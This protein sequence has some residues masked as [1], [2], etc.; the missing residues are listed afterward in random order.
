[1]VRWNEKMVMD[2]IPPIAYPIIL[3]GLSI[4][5]IYR[6]KINQV[7]ET[8]SLGS[9]YAGLSLLFAS[10]LMNLLQRHP[11]YHEWFLDSVYPVVTIG[12]L[13]LIV[14]GMIFLVAGLIIYFSYWRDSEIE[15]T[16]QLE[17]LKVLDNLQ[18]E[19]RYPYQMLE[20]LDRVLKSMLSGLEEEAGAIFLLNRSQ[21][22]FV[23]ATGFGLT[24]E[25]TALLEYYPYG[26]N[27]I[28]QAIEDESPMISADFRS[29]GG[30]AQLAASKFR[31]IL[32]VP[33]ISGKNKLGVL[34]IFS[35]EDRHYSREFIALVT[36]IAEWLSGKIEVN[37]LGRELRKSQQ[38]LESKS[39]R[40]SSFVKQVGGIIR[41][42]TEIPSL[43]VFAEKCLG[44]AGSDEVW[45]IGLVGGR[46]TFYGGTQPRAD[47]SDNFKAAMISSMAQNKA[48][49]LNQ[50]SND[51]AGNSYIARASLLI[52][53]DAHGYAL[54]LR[55]NTGAISVSNEDFQVLEMIASLASM[56]ISNSVTRAVKF[57]RSK[58]IE[59]IGDVLQIRFSGSQPEEGIKAFTSRLAGVLSQED[60]LLLYRRNEQYLRIL[61]S[62]VESEALDNISIA[63][64][65]G[66]TG[67]TA[68]LRTE[69]AFFDSRKVAGN[70]SEYNDE[71]AA[72]L[73]ELFGERG[74]PS[75]QADY[76]VVIGEQVTFVISVFGFDD[77]ASGNME[78]HRLLSLLVALLNLRISVSLAGQVMRGVKAGETRPALT[79]EQL[80]ELNNELSAIS[81]YCQLAMQ[82]PN[83]SGASIGSF[84]S[85]LKTAERMAGKFRRFGSI[86][87]AAKTSFVKSAGVNEIIRDI[88]E[89]DSISGN[90]YMIGNRPLAVNLKLADVPDLDI[91]YHNVQLL[92]QSAIGSFAENVD[93]EEIITVSTYSKQQSIY[94]DIS[95][96]R[97][98]FP[99]VEPVVGF[100]NYSA[101]DL[102]EGKIKGADFLKQL[103]TLSGDF[104]YDRYSKTPSYFSLRLPLAGQEAMTESVIPKAELSILAVDDKA[105]ILDL[106]AAMCQS[107]GYKIHT[108]RSGEEAL[109]I[110]RSHKPGIVLSDLVMTGMSGWELA[111]RIKAISPNTP[112][113]IITGWGVSIDRD[114]MK[115]TGVD[116]ILHKPFR[117]EQLSD[118][119]SKVRL[120]G[121]KG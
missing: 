72:A 54:L 82:D 21:R 1:M 100:G 78:Q 101:P 57:S 71:N 34:L 58:G 23:L 5:F 63:L 18:Q 47:F 33:L 9:I 35:Q 39:Q 116:F 14:A 3:L 66:T 81:G 65:E 17:K 75:F 37:R 6:L 118:L 102:I 112:V 79:A 114:K 80:N 73:N 121:V 36:P 94:I 45:L 74:I 70:F 96:H 12:Q 59:I 103:E 77:S 7:G 2:L 19:S 88:F 29:L 62:N 32:V 67:K 49:I 84:E 111:S 51:E 42:G 64:G 110:F 89:K 24:K 8:G 117:L 90:L 115:Q 30:K 25:E 50:E 68:A 56:I 55:K 44:L 38:L 48:V 60:M 11:D 15:V 31:S 22:K 104:A 106:L 91:N 95:K 97:E 13:V 43:S 27:I 109:K 61:Y 83:L 93:D 10:S 53:V 41:T 86:D 46:L 99:P 4:F 28:T 40:L 76:P 16:N 52:P 69:S 119:I 92:I 98:N 108:A 113:I 107:L 120:S 20:L 26:R 105:V 85:I 87:K